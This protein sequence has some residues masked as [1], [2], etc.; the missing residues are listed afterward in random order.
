MRTVPV[1][2]GART[3]PPERGRRRPAPKLLHAATGRAPTM[4]NQHQTD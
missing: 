4:E 1:E 3:V 2:M